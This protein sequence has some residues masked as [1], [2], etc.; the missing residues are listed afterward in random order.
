MADQVTSAVDIVKKTSDYPRAAWLLLG[1]LNANRIETVQF[2]RSR[3]YLQLASSL[4]LAEAYPILGWVTEN[5]VKRFEK[6]DQART[7]LRSLFEATLLGTELAG[8]MAARSTRQT[9]RADFEVASNSTSKNLLIRSGKRDEA[10]LF[11]RNWVERNA[12]EYLKVCDPFFGPNDLELLQ[13]VLAVSPTCKLHI[14]TSQKHQNQEHVQKPWDEAYRH[15]WRAR[16]SDQNPPEVEFV[17]IGTE[18]A[19][20]LPVHDRWWLSKDCGLRL[21]T[22]FSSLGAN[23]DAELSVLSKEEAEVLEKLVD[24]YLNRIEREHNG[25]KLLYSS[26]NL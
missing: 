2:E 9:R 18:S 23:K 22:S 4:P 10:I 21:G 16:V 19:G 11:V 24:R 1:A 12:K 20:E 7:H 8:K 26:F 17:V 13:I 6:T 14:L 3:E 25:A 15:H 5:S